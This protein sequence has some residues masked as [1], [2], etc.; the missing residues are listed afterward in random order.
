MCYCAEVGQFQ[1]HA[2]S[3]SLS[4]VH[5]PIVCQQ[6]KGPA[7]MTGR[8]KFP[9][10]QQNIETTSPH[11]QPKNL[12]YIREREREER[13]LHLKL[14][15]PMDQSCRVPGSWG[16]RVLSPYGKQEKLISLMLDC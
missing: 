14:T 11:S 5:S 2:L 7:L 16:F 13:E 10:G 9:S 15:Y 8:Y 3:E 6:V 12:T 4:P 1:G